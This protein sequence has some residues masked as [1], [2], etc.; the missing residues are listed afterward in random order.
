M[1]AMV[2]CVAVFPQGNA[3]R[4]FSQYSDLLHADS[5]GVTGDRLREIYRN[6]T[7]KQLNR[8]VLGPD[9]KVCHPQGGLSLTL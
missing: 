6:G 5:A 8:P 2:Q 9:G 1:Q 4:F 7:M 3:S